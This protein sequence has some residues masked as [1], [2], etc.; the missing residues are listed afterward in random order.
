M[1]SRFF[2]A[3]FI[4]T[5]AAAARADITQLFSTNPLG[6]GAMVQGPDAPNANSRFTYSSGDGTLTAHYDSTSPTIKLLFPL[7]GHVTQSQSFT[8]TA[9]FKIP[10]VGFISPPDFGAQVPSFGLVNSATTGD[11][12]ATTGHFD[13]NTFQFTEITQGTAHDLFTF[14]YYP[15]QDITF[16][17]NS[18]NLTTVQSAQAGETFNSRIKFGF[19]NTTLPL[20]QFITASITYD[21]ATHEG[22]LD[23]GGGMITSNLAGALFDVDAFAIILWSDPNLAPPAPAD[24]SGS[25]VGGSIIFDS[26][27]VVLVPEPASLAIL[28]CATLAVL[29]RRPRR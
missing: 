17:G 24:P 9:T 5:L 20:D 28:G 4:L 14:D 29:A 18:L 8:M 7:G 23:W 22:K 13:L 16:G 1:L 11:L 12:R 21:A 15:T 2:P 26:F 25:P 19:A 10:S 6:G 27:S 3:A